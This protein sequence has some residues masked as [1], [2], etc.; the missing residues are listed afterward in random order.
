MKK[1]WEKYKERIIAILL[2]L[3][4]VGGYA[5]YDQATTPAP[6][7]QEV[8]TAD[9]GTL[10]TYRVWYVVTQDGT[11]DT[12]LNFVIVK[13]EEAPTKAVIEKIGFSGE[14]PYLAP[15]GYSFAGWF[16]TELLSKATRVNVPPDD[17]GE[18]EEAPAPKKKKSAEG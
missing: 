3:F 7:P 17:E 15:A 2:T 11:P 1:F 8:T 12:R 4:G 6:P 16:N 18:N 5:T 13:G 9:D 14:P 10:N